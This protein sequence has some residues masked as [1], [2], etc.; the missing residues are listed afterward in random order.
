MENVIISVDTGDICQG[1]TPCTHY[2]TE[3]YDDG[4]MLFVGEMNGVDIWK[5]YG[6]KVDN[7][8]HFRDQEYLCVKAKLMKKEKR[9][10]NCSMV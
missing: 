10:S 6:T 8:A 4:Y 1:A 9:K 2:I 7:P 3:I 5:K